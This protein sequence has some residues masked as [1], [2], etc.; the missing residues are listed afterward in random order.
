MKQTIAMKQEACEE[1]M[2]E[3]GL[4]YLGTTTYD[5]SFVYQRTR[6]RTPVVA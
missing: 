6:H 5:V 1:L 3:H 4:Q 2:R